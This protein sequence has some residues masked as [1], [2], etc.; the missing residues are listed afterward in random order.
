MFV[1]D[2]NVAIYLRDA[3][4]EISR[5][6]EAIADQIFLS[7]VSVVELDGQGAALLQ[8]AGLQDPVLIKALIL[9]GSAL[10]LVLGLLLWLKP[11]RMTYFASLAAMAVMTIVAT[12]M[13]P[14]L[15]LHP[16]GPL[17]KNLPI[18]AML[19]TLARRSA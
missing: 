16:L 4:P 18:A 3:H 5:R 12:V 10:D 14:S 9:A 15:W 2:T 17:L 11:G 13:L 6:V 19:W 1:I 8:Q 7:V